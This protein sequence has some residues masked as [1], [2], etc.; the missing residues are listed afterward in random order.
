MKNYRKISWVP[1]LI[2]MIV[3]PVQ[4]SALV[5]G[6]DAATASSWIFVLGLDA[7][8]IVFVW[9]RRPAEAVGRASTPLRTAIRCDLDAEGSRLLHNGL[10]G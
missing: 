7:L 2:V 10:I 8:M 5:R 4:I 3:I 1:W 6:L 9:C